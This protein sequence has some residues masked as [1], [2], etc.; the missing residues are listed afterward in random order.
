[1]DKLQS[2]ALNLILGTL[3]NQVLVS[4][5]I[6]NKEL[7]Y[8]HANLPATWKM[9]VFAISRYKEMWPFPLLFF[10]PFG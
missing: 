9:S 4:D 8:I 10:L 2:K 1:M 3:D 6:K 5:L 7:Y